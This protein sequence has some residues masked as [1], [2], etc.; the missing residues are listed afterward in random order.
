MERACVENEK[1]Q[2][3]NTCV[4]VIHEALVEKLKDKLCRP[5]LMQQEEDYF[6]ADG[7]KNKTNDEYKLDA[8]EKY[9]DEYDLYSASEDEKYLL[10]SMLDG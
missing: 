9:F 2:K 7:I 4:E 6:E 5:M 1:F 10:C 3:K 8:K